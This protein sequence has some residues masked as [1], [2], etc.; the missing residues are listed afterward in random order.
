[1]ESFSAERFVSQ[2]TLYARELGV[3]IAQNSYDTGE[4][5]WGCTKET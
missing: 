2:V 3:V 5:L 1:L 4:A